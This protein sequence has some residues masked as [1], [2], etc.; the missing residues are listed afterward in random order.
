MRV[1]KRVICVD[2][3]KQPHT[4]EEL[5]NDVPNWIKK[6]QKYTVRAIVDLDFVVGLLLEE[7]SNP[8]KYF[9][10]VGRSM[11]PTFRADRFRELE[12]DSVGVKT[13]QMEGVI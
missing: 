12:E 5:S 11:E 2:D 1:G 6:G 13:E 4:V 9:K 8:I 7:V 3:S 10:V